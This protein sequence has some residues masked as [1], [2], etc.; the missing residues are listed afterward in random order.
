MPSP[1][2]L[3][4]LADLKKFISPATAASTIADSV[5]SEI[6]TGVS[7]GFNRY[8]ARE[9][10]ISS[11]TEVR[12][13]NGL[14]T[15]RTLRYPILSVSS[16]TIAPIN[17]QPG[18][19]LTSNNYSFDSWFVNLSPGFFAQRFSRGFQNVTIN[20]TAGY[21]TPGQLQLLTLP[22]WTAGQTVAVGFQIQ[23][24]G[25]I[26]EVI[27]AGVTDVVQPTFPAV[28]N[29]VV[30]DNTVYWI[31]LYPVPVFPP[32]ASFVPEDLVLACQ[33]Q[34]ALVSKN[35]TRVGDTGVGIGPERISFYLKDMH[36]TTRQKLNRHREV[37]PTEGMGVQ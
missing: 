29:S 1:F 37:F 5:L 17:G 16:I 11:F 32:Q 33:E 4:S 7:K 2:D 6:I 30:K 28:L 13:G 34:A 35:R 15:M 20:Y 25:F 10:A 24:N 26:W 8:L 21:I 22:V 18:Q 31:A 36:E 23:A 19:V 27:A 9:L 14:Q 12:N 3:T